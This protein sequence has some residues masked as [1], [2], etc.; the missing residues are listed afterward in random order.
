M[1]ASTGLIP[2]AFPPLDYNKE[3]TTTSLLYAGALPKQTV[4]AMETFL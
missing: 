2:A 4:E 1:A 3:L